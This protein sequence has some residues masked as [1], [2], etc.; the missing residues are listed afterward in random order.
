MYTWQYCAEKYL[1][2]KKN[3]LELETYKT[4]K[5]KFKVLSDWLDNNNKSNIHVTKI[6]VELISH[7][8]DYM[9]NERKVSN[10]TAHEYKELFKSTCKHFVKV[11]L[12]KSNPFELLPTVKFKKDTK[13]PQIMSDIILHT[14]KNYFLEHDKQMWTVCLFIFYC[15]IRPKE[16]RFLKIGDIDFA[17]G[18]VTVRGEIAKNDKTQTVIIPDNLLEHLIK[19]NYHLKNK[20]DFVFTNGVY[21]HKAVGRSYFS[22]QYRAMR[23]VT[24]IDFDIKFYSLKHTGG[25]KLK[26]SGADLI[27]MKKQFRH[28][29]IEQTYQYICSLENEDSP[30]IRKNGFII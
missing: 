12:I 9:K 22:N 5:S 23:K 7:F 27:E 11:G 30:H 28:Y 18:Y 1:S 6:T 13:K 20:T 3:V 2:Q 29:S 21:T 15:F 19:E 24:G 14:I 10:K 16:L 25:V 4:Y 8:F 26:K 17:E